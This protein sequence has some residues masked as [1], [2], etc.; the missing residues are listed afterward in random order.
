MG[1]TAC[2]AEE[3]GD[4]ERR[5]AQATDRSSASPI[6]H[7]SALALEEAFAQELALFR[8]LFVV[9]LEALLR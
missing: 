4:S 5:S 6:T 9:F 2:R 8:E 3:R 1:R 7:H